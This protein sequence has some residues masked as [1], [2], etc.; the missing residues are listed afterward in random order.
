MKFPS[1]GS[2]HTPAHHYG[3]FRFKTYAPIAFRY[4]RE[5]FCIQPDDYMVLWD[6]GRDFE[7]TYFQ[8]TAWCVVSLSLSQCSLCGEDLIELSNPGASGSLFY[9]SN[10]DQFIMKTVQHKEAE[11]LQKLLP[12]YFMV[13]QKI[14]KMK[15][16]RYRACS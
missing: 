8:L 13:R 5:M 7:K 6:F 2:S 14:N 16:T 4:F 10:D 11:F 3:D 9:L 1:E 15:S 12:G